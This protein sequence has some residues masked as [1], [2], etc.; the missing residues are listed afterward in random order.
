MR[1]V[2]DKETGADLARWPVLVGVGE[3]VQRSKALGA[4]R[5]PVD[6][7]RDAVLAAFADAGLSAQVHRLDRLDVVQQFSWPVQDAPGQLA[8]SLGAQPP[9]RRYGPVGGETPVSFVHEAALAIW[10]GEAELAVVVGAEAQYSVNAASAR[11]DTLPWRPR[12]DATPLLR[13]AIHQPDVAKRLGAAIPAAIYPLFENAAVASLGLRPQAAHEESAQLWAA[14]SAVAAKNPWSWS[15]HAWNAQ[16]IG[17]AAADNRP[18]A[19]PYTKRMVANPAVNQGAAVVL[20]TYAQAL[21]WGLDASRLVFVH[22][23]AAAEDPANV[24]ARGDLACSP[25]RDAVLDA[26]RDRMGTRDGREL[27]ELYSCFPVVP[28]LARRRL[29]LGPEVPLTVTGGL[30]F[31]GAPLNNYMTHAMAAMVRRLRR[32]DASAR[33]VL[34]GQGGNMTK[35]HALVLGCRPGSAADLLA[36]VSV[37]PRADAARAPAPPWA[38]DFEGAAQVETFTVLFARD[39]QPS[40]GVVVLRNAARQRLMARVAADDAHTLA[41]LMDSCQSPVGRWG[42]V[43]GGGDSPQAVSQWRAD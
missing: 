24:M 11:G 29:G 3:V 28:K 9:W 41:V 5:E 19:W 39:G 2:V 10:R 1:D 31:F 13:G 20:C 35:H 34:Y 14:F 22:T 43:V 26:V 33:G 25:G 18:V 37:Q 16:E 21:R 23:G 15:Q 38:P 8:K 4:A 30:S 12:D 40:H 42:K 6:L 27:W 32:Q 7:M 36:P 17:Q